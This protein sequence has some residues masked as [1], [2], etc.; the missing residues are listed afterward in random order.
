MTDPLIARAE[1][2]DYQ[3][4]FI[5]DLNWSRPDH[6]PVTYSADGHALTATNVS[7]YKGLRVWVVNQKPGSK[8]EAALDQL[9]A[10]SST[11]RLVIFH[12]GSEQVWRWPVRRAT[13]G[14]TTTRLSRHLHRNGD[15]DPRFSAK[16]DAIRLPFDVS[17]DPNA[18]LA[19]VRS[20]FD[21]EAENETRHASKLMAR[22]YTSM[23]QAYG[24]DHDHRDRDHQISVTLARI[25]FLMFGDDTDMWRENLFRDF[26]Y[27]HTS[28]DGSDIGAQL[29]GLFEYLDTP[30]SKRFGPNGD[31]NGFRYVNGGIFRERL[32]LPILNPEF[33]N[34]IL[35][36]CDRDWATISPAIFGS[37][38][39]SVRDAQ[40]R[41]DLGEHYTSEANI[42]KTLNPLFLDELRAEFEHIK[43]LGKYEA[44]RLR[45]LRDK[46]GQIRYMD[47]AC[48]CGNFII[49][50]Y[51]ELR[52][53][54]LAIMERL[55]EITGD[56][57]MLLA[58]IGLKVTLDHFFGIEIDEWPA[59]IA[60]TAMFLIDRQCDLKLTVSLGWAPDRLPIQEQATIV[61]GV[62]ALSM[63]WAT[64]CPPSGDVVV[65]GNPPFLGDHTRT[66]EQ[67]AELQAVW[68]GDKVLSRMDYVTGWHAKALH[69]FA[70]HDGL[71]AFVT[72]NSITQ[73]DQVH[74]LFSEVFATGWKI[75]FAHRTFAWTSEAAGAAAVHCVIIGF[76]RRITS[77]PRLFD[78]AWLKASPQEAAVQSINAYLVD[79][80]NIL[81]AKRTNPLSLDM[82]E[83]VKGSMATDGGHLVV[84]PEDY[85][86]VAADPIA[87]RFLRPYV[88]SKE[89]ING[90][91][92]WCL[93]LVN[94]TPAELNSSSELRRR[95]EA[96]QQ[97]RLESR[98]TT[99]R[100]YPHHH[101]FRQFGIT[102]DVPIVCIPEVSSENRDYLPVAHLSGGT[103]ISNK[104]YGAVDPSGLVFAIASSAMFIAWMKT[105]G[106]RMKSDLSFSSTITWNNFPLP[107]LDAP[108]RD[109]I[110]RAGVAIIGARALRADL[111]L[112]EHYRPG[113]MQPEVSEAHQRLDSIVDRTFGIRDDRPSLLRRQEA[114]FAMYG[115]LTAPLFAGITRK[116]R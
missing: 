110:S 29:T 63:D 93:W 58:N 65:A 75:K 98:A 64:V 101:L 28:S 55:Q 37:M 42:L 72:T 14:S 99:T 13:G 4:L 10:K 113:V 56:G 108:T 66:R 46:L 17:L 15:P 87:S 114:L 68:G 61:S 106:G 36:A 12:D 9:I 81:A 102:A 23:E 2:H 22:L 105:V 43:T 33:R 49:V 91:E 57:P 74:R 112:E 103:I 111:S 83:V 70:E 39:Q 30:P 26:I 41:R 71:W 104:V 38:F 24:G 79:G 116:K 31:F 77:K 86:R 27:E 92:R 115:D 34:V 67:L 97:T 20:A 44:D 18:V 95:I 89:L 52:D 21:V 62:S 84:G 69:Y 96:V 85:A 8:L 59:R 53:L 3:R 78:Y 40:T 94:A 82:P 11:D 60:E 54:E 76:T 6:A 5:E 50:A 45:K 7:S 47:P 48:G 109:S 32:A 1:Q 35:E 16:L 51:R 19:K 73:G 80:P 90:K 100:N 25:L 88:G 107:P